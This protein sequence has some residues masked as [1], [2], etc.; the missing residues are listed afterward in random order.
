[1]KEYSNRTKENAFLNL[2]MVKIYFIGKKII[3]VFLLKVEKNMV[4]LK[5]GK[6]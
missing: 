6:Y 1:L 4:C 5:G 3:R 2:I